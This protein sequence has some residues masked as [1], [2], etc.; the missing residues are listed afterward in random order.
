MSELERVRDDG[1]SHKDRP[2]LAGGWR[3]PPLLQE[4]VFLKRRAARAD[5]LEEA[6]VAQI[7]WLF[8]LKRGESSGSTD[9]WG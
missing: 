3:L 1:I 7:S 6:P 9:R 2:R 4:L 5:E 8:G